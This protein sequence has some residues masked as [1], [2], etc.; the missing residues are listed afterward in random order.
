MSIKH[1]TKL[2]LSFPIV[3][4]FNSTF[5]GSY[6]MHEQNGSVGDVHSGYTVDTSDASIN[7]YNPAGLTEILDSITTT[8][9]VT[10]ASNVSFTGRS[11]VNT[12]PEPDPR[13]YGP[14]T[15]SGKVSASGLNVI[16]SAHFARPIN[17][18][19]AFG[20]SI[21]SPFGAELEWDKKLFTRFNTTLNGI[22]TVNL[23]PSFGYK[24]DEMVSIGFGPELQYLEMDINK[25]VG[26]NVYPIAFKVNDPRQY[27]S[28]ISNKLSN[29]GVTWHAGILF[30]PLRNTKIG[31]SYRH[32]ITHKAKGTSSLKGHLALPIG[33][34]SPDNENKTKNLKSNVRIPNTFAVS[35]QVSPYPGY[36]FFST[37]IYTN[38][39]VIKNVELNNV[40][41]ALGDVS[42][43]TPIFIE[44]VS[45]KMN[46]KDTITL[47]T[48]AHWQYNNNL[49]FKV[50]LG[51]DQ[52]PTND[53]ERDLKIPDGNRVLLGFGGK[54]KYSQDLNIEV[55]YMFVNVRPSKINKKSI[56]Q[57]PEG[58]DPLMNPGEISEIYGKSSGYANLV[59]IQTTFNTAKIMRRF[60]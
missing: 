34:P 1:I 8:A 28:Y 24:V 50:G 47:L 22:K 37:L 9:A 42:S 32:G 43:N 25:M 55:G 18:K 14:I 60:I 41:S 59:G 6:Q 15:G 30:K 4:N 13:F 21:A 48:G 2:F 36:N 56:I 58:G 39:G 57:G 44:S 54:Y 11:R 12:Y 40:A 38:W 26:S 31:A 27:D 49:M 23:S 45:N 53:T 35:A 10:A 29:V 51:Y 33:I 16:P 19:L 17:D 20:F 5:A 7:F 52:T 3:L 46:F